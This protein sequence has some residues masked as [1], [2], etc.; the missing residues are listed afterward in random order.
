MIGTPRSCRLE[1]IKAEVERIKSMRETLSPLNRKRGYMA[2]F[3]GSV[4]SETRAK[5]NESRRVMRK[6]KWF[7]KEISK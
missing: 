5:R 3:M 7:K 2:K 6:M 1:T 4:G